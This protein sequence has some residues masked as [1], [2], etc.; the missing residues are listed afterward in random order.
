M[1]GGNPETGVTAALWGGVGTALRTKAAVFCAPWHHL[2]FFV[3]NTNPNVL[4]NHPIEEEFQSPNPFFSGGLDI[5]SHCIQCHTDSDTGNM[6][7][8]KKSYQ[9]QFSLG[10]FIIRRQKDS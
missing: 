9:V 1:K 3:Q 6:K 5:K 7:S 4:M 10:G 2:L 8:H